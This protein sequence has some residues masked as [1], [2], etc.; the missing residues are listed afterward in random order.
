VPCA[1]KILLLFCKMH[2]INV[3]LYQCLSS[4]NINR[5]WKTF[6]L[7]YTIHKCRLILFSPTYISRFNSLKTPEAIQVRFPIENFIR[8][9]SCS[10]FSLFIESCDSILQFIN[11][12]QF[13][14]IDIDLLLVLWWFHKNFAIRKTRMQNESLNIFILPELRV[15][16][17]KCWRWDLKFLKT[18]P[19]Y[20]LFSSTTHHDDDSVSISY[21]WERFYSDFAC[22]LKFI[23]NFRVDKVMCTFHEHFMMTL[24]SEME[25]T[26]EHRHG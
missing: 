26:A 22:P 20:S 1:L 12:I 3:K 6:P 14:T 2:K 13:T 25:F 17:Q 18:S 24:K 23:R 10:S 4:L 15:K 8:F 21:E 19:L 7:Y 11:E 5:K 9:S 16:T